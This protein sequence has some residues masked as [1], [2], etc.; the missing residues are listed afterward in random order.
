MQNIRLQITALAL[1]PMVAVLFFSGLSVYEKVVEYGH[2]EHMRPLTRIAEDSGNAVHV[3]QKERG[4]SVSYIK[5]GY[6]AGILQKLQAHRKVAD[7]EIAIFREHVSSLS[8]DNEVIMADLNSILKSLSNIAGYRSSVDSKSFSVKDVVKNYTGTIEKFIHIIAI[9]TEESPSHAIGSELLP[10][11]TVVEAMESGGLERAN[12]AALLNEY[13]LTGQVN[14]D[15][16]RNY[17]SFYGGELAFLK[18]L[19]VVMTPVQK[20][21]YKKVKQEPAFTRA[22]ETREKLLNLPK[23]Q[24]IGSLTGQ[25]WF[26]MATERLNLLKAFSDD[27]IHRAEA[28]AD[29]DTARLSNEIQ[30]LT[31]LAVVTLIGSGI[32]VFVQMRW[33]T[34]ALGTQKDGIEKL[35]RGELDIEIYGTE[36]KDDIGA[37]ARA[38]LIFRD[39]AIARRSLE[40]NVQRERDLDQLR[41][42]RMSSLIAN[43]R[44]E[45][46]TIQDS[47]EAETGLMTETSEG[48][49]RLADEA[50]SAADTAY[51]ASGEASENVQTVAT[52]ATDLTEAIREISN[53]SA[54][55]TQI[56]NDA[57]TTAAKTN[58]DVLKLAETA[59]KIGAVVE[60][61]RAIAEQ[62]NLLALNA[63]IEAARAGEAGKGF[64]VVAAEVKELS[65]Q[66]AKATDEIADQIGDIQ[67]S[68]QSTVAAIQDI[69]KHIDNVTEVTNAIAA[70][71]EEQSATTAEISSSIGRAADGSTEASQNV[72]VVSNAIGSTRDQSANV[73]HA[74]T[75]LM[76]VTSSFTESVNQF[77][78][79]V[80]RDVEDRRENTREFAHQPVRV[81]A[82][83]HSTDANMSDI[84]EAGMKLTGISSLKAGQSVSIETKNML[85][86]VTIVWAK[87]DA[88]GAQI[89]RSQEQAPESEAA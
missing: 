32:F 71:V 41:Q 4:L 79:E 48:L 51:G 53:Q 9:T 30:L 28:A 61:I 58:E 83:G 3:M 37:I 25:E 82:N 69:G 78:E 13:A 85:Y 40:E 14:F 27:L 50:S 31:I 26:A 18:E 35:A 22:I 2:Y 81:I 12:G 49:V 59:D 75:Q 66:T 21:M 47:L 33:I 5:S 42:K 70:A 74:A 65:T 20:D 34:K 55:A 87:D 36:R 72:S 67:A 80:V 10:Y 84:S 24:S 60:M 17:M 23:D 57:T 39:N 89:T 8:L 29:A 6:D 73:G 56:T 77:L 62:T 19:Q 43:F 1:L 7:K 68:T 76:S 64:A 15:I 52:A 45:V 16:Y 46:S 88:A 38:A 63:T 54:R 86:D 44:S 11:L